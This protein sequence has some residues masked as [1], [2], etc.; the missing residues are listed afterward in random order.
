MKKRSR[1]GGNRDGGPLP[2][3][4]GRPP[5]PEEASSYAEKR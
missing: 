4:A 2:G 3:A 1:Q 5:S